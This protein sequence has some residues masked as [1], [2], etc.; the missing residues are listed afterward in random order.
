M[1]EKVLSRPGGRVLFLTLTSRKRGA[2]PISGAAARAQFTGLEIGMGFADL[3][4]GV[5]EGLC[6]AARDCYMALGGIPREVR[7]TGG[8]TRSRALKLM[9]ASAAWRSG[10]RGQS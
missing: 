5:Y 10:A 9:L 1:D 6:L 2:R 7:L 4:R 8:A 3:M